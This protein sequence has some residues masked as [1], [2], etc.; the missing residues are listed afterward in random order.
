MDAHQRI[1]SV[2]AGDKPDRPAFALWQHFPDAD[3]APGPLADAT[4]KYAR[5]W[6][7]D[8]IK[9]TP[10]G[11]FAVEDW[12]AALTGGRA[13]TADI[14]TVPYSLNLDFDWADLQTLDVSE[15][16]L[17]RELECLRLVCDG[18]GRDV[19]VYMTLF[20]PLTLAGKLAGP[21]LVESM[22]DEPDALHGALATIT[23]TMI[24]FTRAVRETGADGIYFATQYASELLLTEEQHAVFGEPYDL[25][26]LK[27]WDDGGPVILHLCGADVFF[28]L[29]NTYPI[30]AICWDHGLSQPSFRDAFDLT[31]RVLVAGMEERE[32]PVSPSTVGAQAAEALA[33]SGGRRHILAP[34]CVIPDGSSDQAMAAVVNAVDGFR[35]AT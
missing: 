34:T 15:G 16:A 24:A 9:H 13:M 1:R 32:F 10:N 12:A 27:A 33:V 28:D 21:R 11:M 8:L 7:P 3:N 17:A 30:Q 22:R 2:L 19:P 6:K 20:G 25:A 29:C 23:E 26:L 5:Q 31:D 4:I 14:E 35:D 18:I